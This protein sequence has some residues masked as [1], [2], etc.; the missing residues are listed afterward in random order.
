MRPDEPVT[1]A[2]FVKM[3]DLIL[4]VKPITG[5]TQFTDVAP[6]TGPLPTSPRWCAQG[7]S[8]A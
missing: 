6:A 7:S 2:Q 5:K 8:P 3:L 4:G 1:R